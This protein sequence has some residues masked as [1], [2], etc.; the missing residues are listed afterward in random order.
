MSIN[1]FEGVFKDTPSNVEQCRIYFDNNTTKGKNIPTEFIEYIYSIWEDNFDKDPNKIPFRCDGK[2]IKLTPFYECFLNDI[3]KLQNKNLKIDTFAD[4]FK[5]NGCNII[6]GNGSL[7]GNRAEK[8]LSLEDEVV[9]QLI[10]IVEL[11]SGAHSNG[12][13]SEKDFK[14]RVGESK[15]YS[16]FDF[17]DKGGLN[18]VLEMYEKD[19]D[20]DLS[21]III[22]T[23]AGNTHRNDHNELF[24]NDFNI[25]SSDIVKVLKDSGAIIA[26]VTIDTKNPSY[27]SVKMK[28]SQLSGVSYRTAI[29]NN[30]TFKEAVTSHDSWDDIKDSKDMVSYIN[31]CNVMGLYPEDVFEKYKGIYSGN[32]GD[33]NL[34][35]NPKYDPSLLGCLFQKLLGG[36]YWY[37]KP[38]ICEYVGYSD[39]KLKFNVQK[40]NLSDS[41][42]CITIKGDVDGIKAELTFRTDGAKAIGPWPYRMFPKISV[43]DLIKN[44]D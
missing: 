12:K 32:S 19:P 1:I 23:G 38:G 42:K 33:L 41:G 20:M 40:A 3:L 27:I 43:S 44:I 9:S 14:E 16:W 21:K 4:K 30:E 25:T 28:S 15:L 11:I 10:R 8:G 37:S 22:K 36:N 7:K 5:V 29:A 31:L 6:W 13:L 35:I 24:D 26:D 39:A 2:N 34:K 18:D 17:Y